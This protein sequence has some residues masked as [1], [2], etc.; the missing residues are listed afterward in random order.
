MVDAPRMT[1]LFVSTS[2]EEVSTMPVPA[3]A[4]CWYARFV[5]TITTPVWTAA[6][7]VRASAACAPTA[8]AAAAKRRTRARLIS[9]RCTRDC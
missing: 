3:A 1:W 7:E 2:P 4:P 5:F 9:H 8:S 6:R